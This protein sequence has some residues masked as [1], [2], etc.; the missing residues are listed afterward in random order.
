MPTHPYLQYT[1]NLA[2][3]NTERNYEI[4][5]R[6]ENRNVITN[7]RYEIKYA[8]IDENNLPSAEYECRIDGNHN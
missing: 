2:I 7:E 3:I 8:P 1:Y 4:L 6:F 5:Q